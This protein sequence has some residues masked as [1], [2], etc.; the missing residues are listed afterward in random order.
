VSAAAA[1]FGPYLQAQHARRASPARALAVALSVLAHL[2]AVFGLVSLR[3]R[4]TPAPP[5]QPEPVLLRLPALARPK[6]AAAPAPD[7]PT[8]PPRRPP[9][10]VLVQPPETPIPP[11]VE[12]E[13][14]PEP[15]PEEEAADATEGT[16]EAPAPA[17]GP[18]A[19]AGYRAPTG[20]GPLELKDVARAP[21]VLEQVKPE[22]PRD[23]RW[24][25]IEGTVVVRVVVDRQ[26]RVDPARVRVVQSVPAL[27]AAAAAAILRWRFSPAIAHGGQPVP[28][29]IEVP[30]RFNL[31]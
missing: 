21:V 22:Y 15:E 29:I 17:A 30:F 3:S 8:P 13:P 9:R 7:R 28:V 18:P 6:P 10:R 12:P 1:M 19:P 25:R 31:R 4:A 16:D 27:D 20:D 24:Q 26:G 11:A 23:A 14:E 5:P 2:G